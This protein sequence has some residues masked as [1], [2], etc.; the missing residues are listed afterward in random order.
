MLKSNWVQ[1]QCVRG[2]CT[3]SKIMSVG[4]DNNRWTDRHTYSS[5]NGTNLYKDASNQMGYKHNVVG[6]H[7]LNPK[8]M[9][10]GEDNNR[11]TDRQTCSS[12]KGTNL[13]KECSNLIGY[14]INVLG[15]HVLYPKLCQLVRTTTDGQTDIHTVAKKEQ[16]YIKSAQI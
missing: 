4:E 13:Y 16:T 6:V 5:Q 12:Q 2:P 11:Q 1:N 8:I 9:S 10:V 7:I 3:V 14:K 15:V